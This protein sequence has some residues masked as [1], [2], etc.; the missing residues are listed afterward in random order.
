MVANVTKRESGYFSI[1][2]WRSDPT[3]DEA[4]NVAVILVDS[5]GR[6]GGIRHAS[7][8]SISPQLRQQGLLD[9]IL[10]GLTDRFRDEVKPDVAAITKM[11]ATMSGS[12]VF[13]EPKQTVVR[14]V[15]K[16]LNTL[17]KAY[18][19]PRGGGGGGIL[20]KARLLDRTVR[21]FRRHGFSVQRGDY[22]GDFLFHATIQRQPHGKST[23]IEALSFTSPKQDW[24]EDEHDAGYFLYAI[25]RA[26]VGGLG[27]LQPPGPRSQK[28]AHDAYHRVTRWFNEAGVPTVPADGLEA[29]ELAEG[30]VDGL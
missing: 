1:L 28:T 3:R 14:D 6:E 8:S 25:E 23:A 21:V 16:T 7:V 30:L 29:H 20:T 22:L 2:R 12:L 4:R 17:F 13:T 26:P 15:N 9:S 11:F 5:E 10:V 18:V 19:E 27:I 24:T